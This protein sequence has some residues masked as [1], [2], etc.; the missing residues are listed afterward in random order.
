MKVLRCNHTFNHD[1]CSILLPKNSDFSSKHKGHLFK[2]L[3]DNE[4]FAVQ[5]P[6]SK[7]R[8]DGNK[9]TKSSIE[10]LFS[11]NDAIFLSWLDSFQDKLIHLVY[12][13]KHFFTDHDATNDLQVTQKDI[14]DLFQSKIKSIKNGKFIRLKCNLPKQDDWDENT[15][16]L[17]YNENHDKL[18]LDDITAND[19]IVPLLSVDGIFFSGTT[20]EISF[21]L[22]QIMKIN[23]KTT[24]SILI[25]SE[26]KIKKE[27]AVTKEER[28][29]EEDRKENLEKEKNS[30]YLEEIQE[31]EPIPMDN[32]NSIKLKKKYDLLVHTFDYFIQKE[33]L[34]RKEFFQCF[35]TENH[36]KNQFLFIDSID[37][38]YEMDNF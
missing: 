28:K 35:L 24:N 4:Y 30:D 18:T 36:I 26:N 14:S 21:T 15:N 5:T 6:K 7:F 12:E 8:E 19:F 2:I 34:K 25:E 23:M 32:E 38:A 1:A 16:L 11:S 17:I 33:H 10:L 20:F 22:K 29:E 27:K 31:I 9:Y 37:N 3:Y 13:Q